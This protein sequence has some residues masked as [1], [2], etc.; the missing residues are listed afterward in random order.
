MKFRY[1]SSF[2]SSG[3][4]RLGALDVAYRRTSNIFSERNYVLNDYWQPRRGNTSRVAVRRQGARSAPEGR[5]F[6]HIRWTSIIILSSLRFL[7]MDSDGIASGREERHPLRRRL[8]FRS[9]GRLSGLPH[10][11]Y[12]DMLRLARQVRHKKKNSDRLSALM[13]RLEETKEQK[14]KLHKMSTI[15]RACNRISRFVHLGKRSMGPEEHA[16]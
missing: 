7:T 8:V 13:E 12:D 10:A 5:A 2:Q 11:F 16:I 6:V 15:G 1:D 4:R 14:R 3:T 9:Q